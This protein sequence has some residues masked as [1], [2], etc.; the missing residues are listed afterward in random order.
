LKRRVEE[1]RQREL[2]Q[3]RLA[4]QE[5]L[6]AVKI[7]NLYNSTSNPMKQKSVRVKST[8]RPAE[9]DRSDSEIRHSR[10]S[11]EPEKTRRLSKEKKQSPPEPQKS[12]W[13]GIIAVGVAAVVGVSLFLFKK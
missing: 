5:E 2:E 3:K 1:E 10:T 6:D 13:T 11:P 4:K 9:G 12:K 7:K 8:E